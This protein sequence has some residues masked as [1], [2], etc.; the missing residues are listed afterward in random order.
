MTVW[1]KQSVDLNSDGD[2]EDDN[3]LQTYDLQQKR[4]LNT[5]YEAGHIAFVM[6]SCI[7]S[8]Y[9]ERFDG[10]QNGNGELEGSLMM[11]LDTR[12]QVR[13][14]LGVASRWE[15]NRTVV[16]TLQNYPKS[17]RIFY[18]DSHELVELP[19]SVTDARLPWLPANTAPNP[20]PG[21]KRTNE[22]RGSYRSIEQGQTVDEMLFV[23]VK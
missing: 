21:R 19:W 11:L 23:R 2:L 1:E 14:D 20:K 4:L 7:A 15:R 18:F 16:A 8:R 22:S 9:D 6:D 10:D 13:H 5:S 12:T 3:I 17:A